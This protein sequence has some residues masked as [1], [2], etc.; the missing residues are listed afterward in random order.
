MKKLFFLLFIAVVLIAVMPL[1]AYN[2]T[3]AENKLFCNEDGEFTMLVVSDPQCDTKEQWYEARDELEILIKRSNPDFVLI[4]GDMNSKNQI[5][6]NMWKEFIS[7]VTSRNIFWSTTN[8]NHDPFLQRYYKMYKSYDGCLNSTVSTIDPN[9]EYTRPMNYVIPVYSSDGKSIVFAIYG[10]DTGTSN[11]YGYEG[12]TEKQ[13]DWY[14]KQSDTLKRQNKN[15]AVTSIMCM[16]IP[17]TQTLDMFYSSNDKNAVAKKSGDKY[18][19]FGVT[20]QDGAAVENYICENGTVIEKSYIHTTAPQND[21]GLFDAVLK[22]GDVKA[23][24]FG[25]E[26]KTN[27]I[28]SYK[29]VLLGFAGKLSTGCYSDTLCRGGSVIK[30]NEQNPEKFTTSW[31]GSM[32]TSIDLP[33]IYSDGTIAQ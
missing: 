23:I 33:T 8:G 29:G 27:I 12:L 5:P 1:S 25:H 19:V 2:A 4:N 16:H 31:I 11:K 22:Q 24:I 30:F 28:G 26:H 6:Y 17:L 21:R 15:N 14:I 20:D 7:P 32:P 18:T 10:M 9:Y 3:T 13:I